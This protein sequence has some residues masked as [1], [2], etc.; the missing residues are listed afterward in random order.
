MVN[1]N[2]IAWKFCNFCDE[3]IMKNLIDFSCFLKFLLNRKIEKYLVNFRCFWRL[4]QGCSRYKIR[5]HV[6]TSWSRNI[7]ILASSIANRAHCSWNLG[8]DKNDRSFSNVRSAN[9]IDLFIFWNNFHRFSRLQK[10]IR[11]FFISEISEKSVEIDNMI[12]DNV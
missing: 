7:R 1:E 11:K 4:G 8:R 5:L 10:E 6:G 12:A 3:D 2:T 9:G